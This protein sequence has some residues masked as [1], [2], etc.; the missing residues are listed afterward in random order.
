M[1]R[2]WSVGIAVLITVVLPGSAHGQADLPYVY[3]SADTLLGQATANHQ[4]RGCQEMHIWVDSA[5]T[6][7]ADLTSLDLSSTDKSIG[8]LVPQPE[9]NA[10]PKPLQIRGS[11]NVR[12]AYNGPFRGRFRDWS[13]FNNSSASIAWRVLCTAGR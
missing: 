3:A 11:T 9:P 5:E 6:M 8:F 1:R 10:N 7:Y 2:R 13:F 12:D 4:T